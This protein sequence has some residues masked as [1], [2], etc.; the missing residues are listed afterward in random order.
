MTSRSIFEVYWINAERE[1]RYRFLVDL[2]DPFDKPSRTRVEELIS[3]VK[4]AGIPDGLRLRTRIHV[5][6]PDGVEIRPLKNYLL[7][8]S[9]LNRNRF[10]RHLELVLENGS[11]HEFQLRC[12]MPVVGRDFVDR[13][14]VL[15]ALAD[16]IERSSCHL[17]APRRFGKTSVLRRLAEDRPQVVFMDVSDIHSVP[18]FI[19]SLLR[20]A[21]SSKQ[22]AGVLRSLEALAVWPPEGS[23]YG[24]IDEAVSR[25]IPSDTTTRLRLLEQILDGIA[26]AETLLII[27]EFSVF[28][29]AIV[30]HNR[31]EAE[32]FLELTKEM[33]T[34]ATQPSRWVVSGSAGLS[35]YIAYFELT[36]FLDD[37]VPIDLQ[38]FSKDDASMLSEE[39]FYG[40]G[41]TP[42]PDVIKQILSYID[43]P[44]PYF[45]HALI[46]EIIYVLGDR[47]APMVEDV[48][49]AYKTRLL[50][51][52]GNI[53]FR[54]FI[55]RQQIY[56]KDLRRA[57][58]AILR[59]LAKE[60]DGCGIDEL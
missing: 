58:S 32:S 37:L 59:M 7:S 57:A 54:D 2:H 20:L 15:S 3:A 12:G 13:E 23:P 38:P 18:G 46:H 14:S 4:E 44:I 11:L 60:L 25:V 8:D 41:L 31:A 6:P 49:I 53:Y 19:A 36:D 16:V 47:T 48:D 30:E 39:L 55:L 52:I 45:L 27:D 22:I 40:S 35:A 17:R 5:S 51:S 24:A 26:R 33:R 43:P 56:P 34:R 9:K 1:P 21:M 50:G 42:N 10:Q 28:I 29:R